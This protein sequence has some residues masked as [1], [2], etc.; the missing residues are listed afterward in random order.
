MCQEFNT[1]ISGQEE[2]TYFFKIGFL[3]FPS[4]GA[5]SS[6]TNC[7]KRFESLVHSLK[8]L[9]LPFQISH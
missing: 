6:V 7:Q 9:K 3:V 5:G 1:R 4:S 8:I 2:V